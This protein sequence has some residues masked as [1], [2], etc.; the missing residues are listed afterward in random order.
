MADWYYKG[1]QELREEASEKT[2]LTIDQ[3]QA[4][5]SFLNEIGIIDYDI[6]KEIVFDRYCS[7]DEEDV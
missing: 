5:Y 7:D 6:E 4:V 1:M 3:V 2:G